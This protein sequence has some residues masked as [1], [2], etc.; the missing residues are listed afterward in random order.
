[1]Y[2]KVYINPIGTL[3]S[4]V[5]YFSKIQIVP[6]KSALPI[7]ELFRT[8]QYK[9]SR[10]IGQFVELWD[11]LL[12]YILLINFRN[13]TA[14]LISEKHGMTYNLEIEEIKAVVNALRSVGLEN[15]ISGEYVHPGVIKKLESF[16]DKYLD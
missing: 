1:M 7:R 6:S 10:L 5:D 4:P 16:M 2:D 8:I 15:L 9:E 12:N 13:N 3:E 14:Q 11:I